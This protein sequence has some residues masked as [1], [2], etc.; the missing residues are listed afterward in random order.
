METAARQ[1]SEESAAKAL[2]R[3]ESESVS[4][5]TAAGQGFPNALMRMRRTHG[6]RFVQRMVRAG[7]IQAKV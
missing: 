5:E 6:N 1:H 2:A 7:V 3:S 4:H